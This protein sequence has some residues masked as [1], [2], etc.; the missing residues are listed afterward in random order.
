MTLKTNRGRPGEVSLVECPRCD[1]PIAEHESWAKHWQSQ[2][3]ANPANA[4][5]SSA[6][7]SEQPTLADFERSGRAER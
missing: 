5:E 3:P 2:C 4:D 1:A 7:A 6:E